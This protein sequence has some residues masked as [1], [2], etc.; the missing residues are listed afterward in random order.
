MRSVFSKKVFFWGLL[1][2]VALEAVFLL[3]SR[4]EQENP[5]AYPEIEEIQAQQLS[6]F[7]DLS[8]YFQKLAVDKGAVH[9][10]DVLKAVSLPSN[11][12][13]H[14]LGHVVGDILFVQKGVDGMRVCT[15]DLRN[16]CSHS[17][18]VGLFFAKGEGALGEIAGACRNAPGG[19]GAYTMCFHGLG[20]GIL[21]YAG[22]DLEKTIG[23]CKKTGTPQYGS[24]EYTQCVGG[25]IMEMVGGGF[26]DKALWAEQRKKYFTKDDPL[27]PCSSDFITDGARQFCYIYLTP[28][29]WEV[30]GADLGFPKAD[31]FKKAFPL[32]DRLPK[33]D[34]A[35]RD[36]CYGGFGKE[37]VGLVLGRDIRGSAL[38]N[39][40]DAKLQQVYGWCLLAG[41]K[42]GS[43]ACMLHALQ[44]LYWGGENDRS[45]ALRFCDLISTPYYR[46]SCFLNLINAVSFYI[47]DT[48]YREEFCRAIPAVLQEE[49]RG[50]LL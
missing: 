48:R 18:V 12:D 23:L 41:N 26:H 20:H 33:E 50:K 30:V 31:D 34:G 11:I 29:L 3:S 2:L 7:Q 8:A 40:T 39:I 28:Y 42:E 4:Q 38:E 22:Y 13:M 1:A 6:S 27:Y 10:F 43:A 16:S 35:N 49:C 17:I 36:A 37:F 19:K 15:N 47:E 45:I 24:Q 32:C 25:A 21:A 5:G 44:A 9:A 46:N 14:L